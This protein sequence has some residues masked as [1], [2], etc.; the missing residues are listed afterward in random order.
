MAR[1]AQ[2]K[3]RRKMPGDAAQGIIDA[4]LA[5]ARTRAWRTV[6]LSDIADQAGVS[7]AQVYAAF[8]SK[9]AIVGGFMKRIDQRVLG[10]GAIDA[11]DPVRDRLFEVLMRRFDALAPHKDSVAAILSGMCAEPVAALVQVPRVL[12]SMAWMLEA[13]RL[14]ADGLIGLVRMEGLALIYANALRV[15]LT[16]DTSDMAKTMA[17][18]DQGL[19]GAERLAELCHPRHRH[20]DANPDSAAA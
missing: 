9:A 10:G 18:L 14:P 6:S 19:R 3:S 20:A 8:P 17:A 7:L 2:A 16:D 1:K 5:L 4:A 11:A 13:A 15:W 12:C